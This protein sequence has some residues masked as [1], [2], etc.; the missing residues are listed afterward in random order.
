MRAV[1][2]L[3]AS[4]ISTL[5]VEAAKTSGADDR[6]FA[7]LRAPTVGVG[8]DPLPAIGQYVAPATPTMTF[9]A[10]V[11]QLLRFSRDVRFED[12]F[13]VGRSRSLRGHNRRQ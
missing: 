3:I 5:T 7:T 8:T 10:T 1:A 9:I 6:C 4:A 11:V 13:G 12:V 2:V